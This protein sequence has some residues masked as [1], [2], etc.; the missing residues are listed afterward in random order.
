MTLRP[1]DA[2]VME[3]GA[4][5][6]FEVDW[7]PDMGTATI[8]GDPAVVCPGL[9]LGTITET[10]GLVSFPIT[11]VNTGTYTV[12][13]TATLSNAEILADVIRV[14]V[15]DSTCQSRTDRYN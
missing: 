11:A 9:T 15:I 13:A 10:D 2:P 4:K 1:N 7:R 6:I 12:K 14:Q 3:V 8:D 5:R